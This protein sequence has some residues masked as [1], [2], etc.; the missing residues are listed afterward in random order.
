[1]RQ[2]SGER[3]IA[4]DQVIMN[5]NRSIEVEPDVRPDLKPDRERIIV[6]RENRR[7]IPE[8][9]LLNSEK[10]NPTGKLCHIR[11]KYVPPLYTFREVLVAWSKPG[12]GTIRVAERQ[13]RFRGEKIDI[14]RHGSDSL[15]NRR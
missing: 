5:G 13:I 14:V 7:F 4:P 9:S 2:L 15:P 1:V 8:W 3:K 10:A 11:N 12:N 6:C